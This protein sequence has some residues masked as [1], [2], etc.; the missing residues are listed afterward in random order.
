MSG[1]ELLDFCNSRNPIPRP[2]RPFR[3]A[4]APSGGSLEAPPD[5]RAPDP[6]AACCGVVQTQTGWVGKGGVSQN[7]PPGRFRKIPPKSARN[8]I[9]GAVAGW[10]PGAF[11]RYGSLSARVTNFARLWFS[12]GPVPLPSADGSVRPVAVQRR[13]RMRTHES[14][15]ACY[16]GLPARALFAKTHSQLPL[17][18]SEEIQWKARVARGSRVPPA[19]LRL[20]RVSQRAA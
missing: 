15:H 11:P 8:R 19:T 17:V 18:K 12:Y 7:G 1:I 10:C 20:P 9:K 14:A 2:R 3:R 5:G 13:S 16:S 6:A 4:P